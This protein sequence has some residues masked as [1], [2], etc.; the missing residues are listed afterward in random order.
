MMSDSP[1]WEHWLHTHDRLLGS[2]FLEEPYG[3]Q[4]ERLDLSRNGQIKLYTFSTQNKI[5]KEAKSNCN[6]L[7][8]MKF[9]LFFFSFSSF[10]RD[11]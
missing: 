9:F 6:S 7:S 5:F 2:S 8:W 3:Q 4:R 10:G 11:F 1:S